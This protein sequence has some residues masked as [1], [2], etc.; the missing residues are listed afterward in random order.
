MNTVIETNLKRV[1][2]NLPDGIIITSKELSKQGIYHDLQRIYEKSGWLTR[3]AHGAYVKLSQKHT[4]DGAI[5]ALQNQLDLSIHIGGYTALNDIYGKTHNIY[6]NRSKQLFGDHK[7][8]LPQWFKNIYQ[9]EYEL[10]NSS[11][12]PKNIGLVEHSNDNFSVMTSSAERA[13]LEMLYLSP[14]KHSLNEVY[15]LLELLVELKPKILQELLEACSS[16]RVKR[17][18]LYMSDKIGHAWFKRLDLKKIN[19]GDGVREITK[20]GHLDKKYNIVIDE[21]G[22]I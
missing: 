8:K 1:L 3:I 11:F 22:E 5:F 16:V 6:I 14:K 13:I 17:V 10:N 20:N 21:I 2:K 9:G 4:I 12:L 15:Q 7:E 19:L 18:F